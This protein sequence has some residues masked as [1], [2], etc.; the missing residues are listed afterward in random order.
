[1]NSRNLVAAVVLTLVSASAYAVD[2][3]NPEQRAPNEASTHP[4]AGRSQPAADRT[5]RDM[6]ANRAAPQQWADNRRPEGSMDF[7]RNGLVYPEGNRAF[8]RIG[9]S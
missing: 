5:Q 8:H 4:Q 7:I 3:R 6:A 2:E 1:M 9:T